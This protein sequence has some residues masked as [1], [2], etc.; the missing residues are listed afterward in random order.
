MLLSNKP[1]TFSEKSLG[2]SEKSVET[3][4]SPKN[5]IIFGVKK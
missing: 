4:G 3:R 1:L 2:F 5:G